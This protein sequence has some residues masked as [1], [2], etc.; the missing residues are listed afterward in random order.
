MPAA[1]RSGHW[2]STSP[3]SEEE[4]VLEVRDGVVQPDPD[5]GVTSIVVVDRHK[6]SSRVGKGFVSKLYLKR[7]PSPRPCRMTRTIWMVI[8]AS[9]DDMA[10]AANRSIAND[11]G[12]AI[13]IDREVV[14]EMPLPIA[15]LMSN[16]PLEVMAA[17]TREMVDIIHNKLGAPE[18][19]K[20]L[21]R[22]NGI[23]LP[24]IPDY[25]FTDFGMMAT[26]D[27]VSLDLY[28]RRRRRAHPA[29][30]MPARCIASSFRPDWSLDMKPTTLTALLAT[31]LAALAFAP[32]A[33][34]ADNVSCCSTGH[35]A[36]LPPWY[37]GIK[38]G[39]FPDQ[40]INLTVERG[41][42]G[43]DTV[44][45]IAAGA[46]DFGTADLSS[47]MLAQLPERQRQGEG[48]HADVFGLSHL[49][50]ACSTRQ[51][52]H[53]GR[54]SGRQ[55]GR[56]SARQFRHQDL[57]RWPSSRP[58][59]TSSS[60]RWKVKTVDFSTL[61]GLLLQGKV[62]AITTYSTSAMIIQNAAEKVGKKVDVINFAA[63]LGVY[64]NS[65]LA[66]DKTIETKP[67]LVKRFEAASKCAFEKTRDNIPDAV[68]AMNAAVG[69]MNESLHQAIAKASL[70]LVFDNANYKAAGFGWNPEGV[71]KT[72]DVAERAQGLDVKVDPMSFV[73]SK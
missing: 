40:G 44:T 36:A 26:R 65:I 19:K 35:R 1:H 61:T 8:G 52:H 41:Y 17:R 58:A 33:R 43:G 70:A 20:V 22:M 30:R 37:Y 51:R 60:P 63:D 50:S 10:L 72:L 69:G 27:L 25:G 14:F 62:D 56:G 49:D 34:A 45:K 48:D 55:D 6:A 23:S 28:R 24:N 2:L 11:G 54:R 16:E 53:Q 42:G 64:S 4:F 57:C 39:C 59:P 5:G 66:S 13:V 68:A 67:D 73:V 32:S 46:G 31:G 3:K 12:Y 47:I 18:M 38:N 21:L 7:G 71:K 9:H 15:G 29:G